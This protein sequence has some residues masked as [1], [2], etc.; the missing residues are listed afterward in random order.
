MRVEVHDTPF[1]PWKAL[2]Q[3]ENDVIAREYPGKYGASAVFVGTMRDFN[4]GDEI[5]G[6]TLEHYPG[7]TEKELANIVGE[8]RQRWQLL[9]ELLLHR[10]GDLAPNDPIVL[11]AVWSAHRKDAFEA[12]RYIMEA[13]KSRAPFWKKEQLDEGYRWVEKNTDGY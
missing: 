4:E 10:V 3:Y 11:V 5:T 12:C 13:L 8:A 6:M 9:E 2:Q 1:H 7:M